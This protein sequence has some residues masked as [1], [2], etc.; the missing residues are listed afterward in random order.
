MVNT[1]ELFNEWRALRGE[2]INYQ[3]AG[4]D[5]IMTEKMRERDSYVF[6]RIN[7]IEKEMFP[8]LQGQEKII[9]DNT[10][11]EN[12]ERLQDRFYTGSYLV[13]WIKIK[14]EI[15]A[16]NGLV[17]GEVIYAPIPI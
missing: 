8:L 15:T 13:H 11:I 4:A 7:E 10:P 6:N 12:A 3:R 9:F 5:D 14:E 1:K 16:K 17:S 2:S